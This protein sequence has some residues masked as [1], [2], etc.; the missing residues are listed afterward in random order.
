[1]PVW[2]FDP[3]AGSRLTPLDLA[4]LI[5][6]SGRPFV[7]LGRDGFG[8]LSRKE[9]DNDAHFITNTFT[10]HK[11]SV[12]VDGVTPEAPLTATTS[13]MLRPPSPR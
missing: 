3:P 9:D 11:V 7:I 6:D 12:N 13:R 8:H 4:D 2:I 10:A 5:A 1:M